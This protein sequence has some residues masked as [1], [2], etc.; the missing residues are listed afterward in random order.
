[1]EIKGED[2]L[3][4]VQMK[5][6]KENLE[7]RL[8]ELDNTLNTQSNSSYAYEEQMQQAENELD[9]IMLG[10]KASTPSNTTNK[11]KYIILGLSLVVLF[12]FTII[13]FKFIGT[14]SENP[15][16]LVNN[17]E[18]LSQDK[19]LSDDNIEQQ[20]QKIINEKLQN[21]KDQ[22]QKTEVE[23]KSSK[24]S[25]NLASIEKEEQK[26]K[27]NINAKDLKKTKELKKDIFEISNGKPVTKPKKQVPKS[28]PIKAKKEIEKILVTPKKQPVIPK[29][30]VTK[31]PL[32]KAQK[33]S[34]TTTTKPKGTFVQIGA[35]SK[36][37][38]PKYLKEITDKGLQYVLYKVVINGKLYTKVLIGPYRNRAHAKTEEP[39]IKKKLQINNAFVLSF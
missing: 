13:L 31:A 2:F 34:K 33:V 36:P 5:Q 39:S 16:N 25:L 21:I 14:K 18:K 35:F 10:S 19:T 15:S 24:E 22:N 6:E 4:N 9:D 30:T 7:T 37:I 28:K 8:E 12:L 11:K 20:Y 32:V 26:V 17:E 29:K 1:M 3:R 27:P 38:N 23:K